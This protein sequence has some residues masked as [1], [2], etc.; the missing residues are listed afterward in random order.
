MLERVGGD[1]LVAVAASVNVRCGRRA[2]PVAQ[3]PGREVC[4]VSANL[5]GERAGKGG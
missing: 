3:Q 1:L 2:V 4:L 5:A